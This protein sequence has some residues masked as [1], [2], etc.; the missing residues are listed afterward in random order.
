M[1]PPHCLRPAR[2]SGLRAP[3]ALLGHVTLAALGAALAACDAPAE[4]PAE[5]R[6]APSP[7]LVGTVAAQP[8][9]APPSAT[10]LSLPYSTA[11]NTPLGVLFDITQQGTGGGGAFRV[12]NPSSGTPALFAG[13]AGFAYTLNV[14]NTGAGRAGLFRITS[15]SNG[16]AAVEAETP[17]S[18]H[19]VSGLNT[20]TGKGGFFRIS[21]TT[22]AGNALEGYTQGNGFAVYGLTQGFGRAG[23]F[24]VSN[25]NNVNIAL[26]TITNG[27]GTA[28][29]ANHTGVSGAIAV[30]Q[31]GN[32]NQIRFDK[33]GKGFFN[34]SIQVGG[35]D[36]AET[37][38]VEGRAADYGP[39][40]V[41]VVSTRSDRRVERSAGA[42]ST[43]V[44]GVYATKPGVVLTEHG[45]DDGLDAMVPL[46]VVGVIPT[47][48]SA[49]NGRV[50]RGDLLV[51]A[52]TRGHAMRGTDRGRLVGAIVGRALQEFAGPGTGVI[53]VLVSVR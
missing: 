14:F 37:F 38:A 52:R 6:P 5:P 27:R 44:V 48:V 29:V 1:R 36:V 18:G 46:G 50:R 16:N 47:K 2:T 15:A 13:S 10:S 23:V 7:A 32:V 31:S 49:E 9:V 28:F 11:V 30:F 4:S 19:A 33:T 8:E 21:N 3:R 43:R 51:T 41:L 25:P 42:Y 35:A 12:S 17:G 20:G 53:Q 34:G 45:I 39:G 40:D 24:Q 22:S 26:H